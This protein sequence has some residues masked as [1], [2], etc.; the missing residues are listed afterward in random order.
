MSMNLESR[1]ART[2]SDCLWM[3]KK[4]DTSLN[5]LRL[6]RNAKNQSI[7]HPYSTLMTIFKEIKKSDSNSNTSMSQLHY[8][9]YLEDSKSSTVLKPN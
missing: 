4:V 7:S 3:R 8:R 5:T 6:S 2:N 1:A 9:I